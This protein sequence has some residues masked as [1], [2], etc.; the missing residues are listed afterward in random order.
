MLLSCIVKY[1]PIRSKLM[2]ALKF[3][4]FHLINKVKQLGGS[5]FKIGYASNE[6]TK[7]ISF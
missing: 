2:K 5:F 6:A 1:F 3:E 4:R 7:C